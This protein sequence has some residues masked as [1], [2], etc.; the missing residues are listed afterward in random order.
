MLLLSGA[1]VAGLGTGGCFSSHPPPVQGAG[2]WDD[3]DP[4]NDQDQKN[5][6][7][8]PG[9]GYYHSA[10]HAWYPFPFDFHRDDRGY[11]YG[12]SWH[13]G[14]FAGVVPPVSRPSAAGWMA[15]RSTMAASGR[16]FGTVSRGGFGATAAGHAS[17][18][19]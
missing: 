8:V 10:F 13:P 1:L 15:A 19:A 18:G 11:Y 5:N 17:A 9:L 3:G 2:S 12:G 6:S 14:P 4:A 7:Y 16:S